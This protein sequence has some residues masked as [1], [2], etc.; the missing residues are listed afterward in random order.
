MNKH[1]CELPGL[2]TTY[3]KNQILDIQLEYLKYLNRLVTNCKSQEIKKLS[4]P[5]HVPNEFELQ[6]E[7]LQEIFTKIKFRKIDQ[8]MDLQHE[9]KNGIHVAQPA[10]HQAAAFDSKIA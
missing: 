2:K 8:S 6:S 1:R 3:H 10:K 4:E 9:E 7:M 5:S